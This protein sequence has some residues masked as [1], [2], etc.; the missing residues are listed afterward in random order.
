[1]PKNR[2]QDMSSLDKA[3]GECACAGKWTEEQA[4]A[5]WKQIKAKESKQ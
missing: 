4:A 5:W 1:M 2:F 3:I